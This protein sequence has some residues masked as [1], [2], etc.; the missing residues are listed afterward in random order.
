MQRFGG[1]VLCLSDELRDLVD[2]GEPG[3]AEARRREDGHDSA[4]ASQAD[5]DQSPVQA[6]RARRPLRA[7]AR[8][9][10]LVAAVHGHDARAAETEVVLERNLRAFDLALFGGAA[11]L[12]HELGALREAGR[13][14][15]MALRE[16]TT[17]RVRDEL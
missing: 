10:L 8:G 7:T 11:Q 6:V 16:Q 3:E 17:R 14:E 1:A 4:Q 5:D 9:R 2:D 15:R 13:A 12:P